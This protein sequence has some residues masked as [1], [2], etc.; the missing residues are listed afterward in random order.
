MKKHILLLFFAL[1]SL[2]AAEAQVNVTFQ[3]DMSNETV[4]NNDVQVVIK[5]PWIW[6]A[7]TDQGN[8]IWS[9]T[10][11]LD[12]DNA[13]PYT[14]VNGG[15]DN[16]DGEETLPDECN[17]GTPSAPQR[18][19]IV[20]QEDVVLNVVNFGGCDE[21][22]THANITFQVNINAVDNFHPGG[23]VWVYMDD[24]WNEWYTMTDEDEDGIY[25]YT[26]ERQVESYLTYRYSYQTGP[27][28]DNDYDTE[29]VPD[30][31][32]NED[33]FRFITVPLVDT[34]LPAVAYGSCDEAPTPKVNVTF[35]VDMSNE[36][37]LNNDVQVVIKD[38][39]IW[40]ALTD[41]GNGTWSATVELDGNRTYPF[42]YVNGGQD[43]W[44]GEESVPEDCN[45]GA[46]SAPER[47]L[48]VEEADIVLDP[49]YFGT[50]LLVSVDDFIRDNR[51]QMFPNPAKEF[52]QLR[53]D[54]GPIQ[55]VYFVDL[56][57]R[58]VV[59]FL[60]GPT[61]AAKIDLQNLEAGVYIAVVEAQHGTSKQKIIIKR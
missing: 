17:F 58:V 2:A 52:L 11:E 13:Y 35:Q 53:S 15:Q 36:T 54:A 21:S 23:D 1:F 45:F 27:D 6:T 29:S 5:D 44:E 19:V 34:Q 57:G 38:P 42:T 33:G 20:G 16:W 41:Q 39:W 8:G 51:I 25:T 12:A 9:A 31:C 7:L 48:I 28:P 46:E 55:S 14:F 10:V 49:L 59:S 26:L 47:Q 24:N 4:L 40:T 3:V 37:V 30:D 32:A 61:E 43:N 56:F 22:V 18:Q 60:P 50:C